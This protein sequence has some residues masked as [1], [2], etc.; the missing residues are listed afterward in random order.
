M[1]RCSEGV[2]GTGLSVLSLACKLVSGLNGCIGSEVR[3]QGEWVIDFC[4]GRVDEGV[5]GWNVEDGEVAGQV[6]ANVVRPNPIHGEV[7]ELLLDCVAGLARDPGALTELYVY[8]D[9]NVGIA[10][11]PYESLVLFLAKH[12]FPDATPGGP[13]TMPTHQLVCLD[14]LLGFMKNMFD[15]RGDVVDLAIN[16]GGME[17]KLRKRVLMQG[18]EEFNT[19]PKAGIAFLQK[20]G[21]LPEGDVVD[22]EKLAA[23]LKNTPRINKTRLGEYISK[24]ENGEVLQAFIRDFKFNGVWG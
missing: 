1:Q 2:S 16:G 6:G 5:V 20:N 9:C 7:R 17:N 11:H 8:F 15:R 12:V 3:L 10:T 13:V 18:A 24:K 14:A 21:F 22:P 4:M 23:V 19:K